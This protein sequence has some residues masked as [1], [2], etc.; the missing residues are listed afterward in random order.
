MHQLGA[1][2]LL[3]LN[4]LHRASGIHNANPFTRYITVIHRPLVLRTFSASNQHLG[5][6]ADPHQPKS[7]N[8]EPP[9]FQENVYTIPNLLTVSRI[10]ACPVLGWS[11]L[12]GDFYLATSLL[13]YAGFTDLVCFFFLPTTSSRLVHL[14]R[15]SWPFDQRLMDTWLVDTICVPLL[16]LYWIQLQTKLS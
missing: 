15:V 9:P 13:L 1:R 11:V 14:T 12:K 16:G 5:P 4:R 8:G 7:A 10:L 3:S 2:C 6:K